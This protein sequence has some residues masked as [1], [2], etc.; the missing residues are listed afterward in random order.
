MKLASLIFATVIMSIFSTGL[1]AEPAKILKSQVGPT[2]QADVAAYAKEMMDWK[3]HMAAVAADKAAGVPKEKAHAPFPPPIAPADV[4]AAVDD[5]GTPNY[6][7]VD[8]G[9]TPDQVL[10][11]KKQA[12]ISE[13]QEAEVAQIE[14]VIPAAKL[15]AAEFRA[16]DIQVADA[17]AVEQS[18]RAVDNER[19]KLAALNSQQEK[20]E[21]KLAAEQPGLIGAA[22]QS[23]TGLGAVIA[24]DLAAAKALDQPIADQAAV[25]KQ[26]EAAY[27]DRPAL[28]AK[29]RSPADHAFMLAREAN[30]KTVESIHRW[31]AQAM[32]DVADLT[33]ANVDAWKLPP[34]QN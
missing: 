33:T 27:A 22:M 17:A 1:E 21:M 12:L 9:P 4:A 16:A 13:I 11:A 28:M 6:V 31:A 8:D 30:R 23:M 19:N 10:A 34:F 3:A 32:S 5:T 20:I 29:T 18:L 14:K 26:A 24:S 15:R 7:I 25:V 2:F